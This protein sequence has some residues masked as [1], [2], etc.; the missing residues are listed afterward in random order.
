MAYAK[1]ERAVQDSAGNLVSGVY[2]EVR[3]ESDNGLV[4]LYAT[5]SGGA[6]PNPA[7][8]F[9]GKVRFYAAGTMGGLKVRVHGPG[10]DITYRNEAAGNM[11]ELDTDVLSS[12]VALAPDAIVNDLAG[13][14]AYNG[15]SAGYIVLVA[16]N[17]DGRSAYYRKT[18]AGAGDWSA[19]IWLSGPEGSAGP[20]Y[21]PPLTSGI[22]ES[23]GLIVG[24]YPLTRSYYGGGDLDHIRMEVLAGTGS[25]M[26]Y[27][28]QDGAPVRGPIT[29]AAGTPYEEA[30]ANLAPPMGSLI[31]AVIVGVTGDVRYLAIQIDPGA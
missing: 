7:G 22:Q 31:D 17:G 20:S 10:V 25:V 28:E 5:N 15:Q 19:P 18:G 30:A 26:L 29:V 14:A 1:Y 8:P 16:D 3:R 11:A 2:A 13:R 6:L 27:L 24:R 4:A 9:D 12:L 23:G 21:P